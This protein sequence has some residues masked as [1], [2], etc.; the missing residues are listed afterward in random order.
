MKELIKKFVNTIGIIVFI[1]GVCSADSENYWIPALIV[2]F[3]LLL[4]IPTA[5]EE[6]FD[7]YEE[8]GEKYDL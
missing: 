8:K 3:G 7:I 2:V 6:M 1:I 5:D 4:I